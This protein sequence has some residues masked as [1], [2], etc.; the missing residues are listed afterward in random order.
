MAPRPAWFGT[1]YALESN[2]NAANGV[3]TIRATMPDLGAGKKGSMPW[4]SRS[5][6]FG[7][8]PQRSSEGLPHGPFYRHW[9]A[10]CTVGELMGIGVATAAG[11]TLNSVVGEPQ[12][13]G[14]RVL[15]LVVLAVVGVVEG[16]ALA[17]L[18]WRVLRHRLPRLS[19]GEWVG[20]AVAVTGWIV[21]MTPSLFLSHESSTSGA[22]E[23]LDS[24]GVRVDRSSDIRADRHRGCRDV[25]I[26]SNAT[27]D[28]HCAAGEP[29]VASG[30]AARIHSRIRAGRR[31]CK[32]RR[33]RRARHRLDR[34][35]AL[36]ERQVAEQ[37]GLSVATLRAW[38]HRGKGPRFVRFGRAVRYLAPDLDDFVHANVVETKHGASSD[39]TSPDVGL[40]A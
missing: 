4:L 2:A 22:W 1:S 3:P 36:T 15:V 19:A 35:V 30:T 17:A 39:R 12:S 37:L 26:P 31:L 18:Q 7:D 20:V 29:G 24:A 32:A 23:D 34:P 5:A 27:T 11:V 25:E 9:I 8:G 14:A 38:R 33:Q 21:G 10:A 6:T 28:L 13:L 16:G 40:L